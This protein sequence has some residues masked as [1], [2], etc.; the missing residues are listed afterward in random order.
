MKMVRVEAMITTTM[1]MGGAMLTIVMIL[2]AMITMVLRILAM[3]Q[4]KEKK[5]MT[6]KQATGATNP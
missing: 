2:M 6:I 4:A 3:A 5:V 1:E